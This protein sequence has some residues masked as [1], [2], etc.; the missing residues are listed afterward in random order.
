MSRMGGIS[1]GG[2][3]K[4][5]SRETICFYILALAHFVGHMKVEP[6]KICNFVTVRGPKE[7]QQLIIP[8]C[9]FWQ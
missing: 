9:R 3:Y 5:D 7:K 2:S 1:K 6:P 4:F 8:F